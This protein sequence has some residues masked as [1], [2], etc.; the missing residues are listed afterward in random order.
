VH[1]ARATRRL[2]LGPALAAP[3]AVAVGWLAVHQPLLAV[4]LA[5]AMAAAPLALATGLTLRGAAIALALAAHLLVGPLYVQGRAPHWLPLLL[6]FF[7]VA[8]FALLAIDRRAPAR[9]WRVGALAFA[10]L[11]VAQAFNP[12]LPSIGYG[13]TGARP[14]VVPLLLLVAVGSGQLSRRDE[15]AL[16]AVGVIGWVVN[17]FFASRQWLVGFSGAELAFIRSTRATYLVGDQIRLIGAMRSN[18]DFAFLVAIAFPAVAV[19]ALARGRSRG[20]RVGFGLLALATLAVLFGSLVRSALV[21][22]ML[23][24]FAAGAALARDPVLRRRIVVAAVTVVAVAWV[25]A[26][27]VAGQALSRD[28]SQTLQTR[29]S[30]IFSPGQDYAFQQRQTRVWPQ[31]IH[32]IESHPLGVGAGAAG[33]LSQARDDAPLGPLVPDDGYLLVA[34]DLGLPGL[35]LFVTALGLMLVELWRRARLGA[36]AAVAAFGALVALCVA[37]VT[38][39]FVSLIS[40]SCA[41]AVLMGLGLRAQPPPKR[42]VARA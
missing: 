15:R 13:V 22:G 14:L 11:I 30:S 21:A 26:T 37:M 32:V 36:L 34:V 27:V 7:V 9:A 39:N 4:A 28:Q 25:A 2:A 18:Q 42:E 10:A 24:T 12:L 40:P 8:A 31:A 41:W 20:W 35:A 1:A 29:V 19:C 23:G 33:P 3:P 38:G 6:D 17:A 5:A 16:V